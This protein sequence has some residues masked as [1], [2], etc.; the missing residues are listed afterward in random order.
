MLKSLQILCPFCEIKIAHN[1]K[2]I[3]CGYN[4]H[5][6]LS[7]QDASKLGTNENGLWLVRDDKGRTKIEEQ[8]TDKRKGIENTVDPNETIICKEDTNQDYLNNLNVM[9]GEKNDI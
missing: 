3:K 4:N 6:E 1:T 7:D 8:K 5:I 9:P 2:C